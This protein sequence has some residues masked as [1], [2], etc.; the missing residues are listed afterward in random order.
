MPYGVLLVDDEQSVTE[1][2]KRVLHKQSYQVFC[3]RSAREG[4]DILSHEKIDVVVSD[5]M[6][7]GLSGSEFLGIVCSKYPETIRIIL[8]GRPNLDS[9]LRAI[10]EGHIYRFLIKPCRGLELSV[11]IKQA[12]L[13]KE[14]SRQSQNLLATVR[15]QSSILEDLE[16]KNPGITKV[17]RDSSGAIRIPD[18]EYDLNTLIEEIRKEVDR[19]RSFLGYTGEPGEESSS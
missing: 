14:L 7:P 12:I 5:E 11:T 13:E 18:E 19:T 1:A 16:R 2:L 6:M 4:L 10:N 15:H 9:A 3:A 8:T 17:E